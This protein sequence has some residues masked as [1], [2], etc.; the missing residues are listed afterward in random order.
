MEKNITSQI[1]EYEK[2]KGQINAQR[3]VV[4]NLKAEYQKQIKLLEDQIANLRK[5]LE[6]ELEPIT[7][8]I[9]SQ[10]DELEDHA[11]NIQVSI[12]FGDIVQE[13]SD[14]TGTPVQDINVYGGYSYSFSPLDIYNKGEVTKED[15]LKFDNNDPLHPI[16]LHLSA[17]GKAPAHPN[18]TSFEFTHTFKCHL[19]DIQSDGKTLLEHSNIK[20][21]II[22]SNG[23]YYEYTSLVPDE[24]L[25]DILCPFTLKQLIDFKNSLKN[26][27]LGQAAVNCLDKPKGKQKKLKI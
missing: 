21:K 19:L 25:E 22:E 15:F 7:R 12:K 13:I 6:K 17:V 14:I 1:E 24:N 2:R 23:S 4:A 10:E 5:S 18:C 26:N 8:Q 9:Q 16:Y 20:S 11:K 3:E 27:L